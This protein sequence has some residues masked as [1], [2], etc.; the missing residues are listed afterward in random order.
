MEQIFPAPG[1]TQAE[2]DSLNGRIDK[3]ALGSN[4][5]LTGYTSTSN[6][7]TCTA[8]G[9]VAMSTGTTL[10]DEIAVRINGNFSV[11]AFCTRASYANNNGIFVK[12]GMTLY[13]IVNIGT[14]NSAV[15]KP[16]Q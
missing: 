13:T 6:Q 16:L 10:N 5:D 3:H 9:Y 4:V 11:A 2:F 14:S 8:D 12:K 15:F 7:Y 1:P